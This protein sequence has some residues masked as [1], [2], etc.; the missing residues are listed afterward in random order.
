MYI[1]YSFSKLHWKLSD[2]APQKALYLLVFVYILAAQVPHEVTMNDLFEIS[3]HLLTF[4][5]KPI[6]IDSR[7]NDFNDGE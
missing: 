2:G 4:N 7:H 6:Y 3:S 1:I 5:V